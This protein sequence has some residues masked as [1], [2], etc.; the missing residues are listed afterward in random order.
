MLKEKLNVDIFCRCP[1]ELKEAVRN[2]TAYMEMLRTAMDDDNEIMEYYLVSNWLGQ[3][4]FEVR[5]PL[6]QLSS[7]CL[8]GRTCTGLELS[9]DPTLKAIYK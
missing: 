3:K 1:V 2:S 8:W 4:L 5:Q 9:D 6:M 7:C